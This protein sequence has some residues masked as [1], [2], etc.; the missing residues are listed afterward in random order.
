MLS[1]EASMV[2]I[3]TIYSLFIYKFLILNKYRMCPN[4]MIC[5]Y[6]HCL[7]PGFV[8]KGKKSEIKKED[9]ED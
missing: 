5:H 7:P 8:F 3:G 1:R 2:G 9:E 6:R 4:G